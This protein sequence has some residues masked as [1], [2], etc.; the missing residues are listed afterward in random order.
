MT[1][2]ADTQSAD[3]V[4]V[5]IAALN[6]LGIGYMLVGSLSSNVYGVVRSTVDAGV[7]IETDDRVNE[8]IQAIAEHFKVE[9]QIGF[10]TVGMTTKYE[11]H[12]KTTDFKR[13]VFCLTEDEHKQER[14]RR[15]R[16]LEHEGLSIALPTAEDVVI[17]KLRWFRAKG[18]EDVRNVIAVQA[19]R[20]D[21]AYVE[22]WCGRL[23]LSAR[24]REVRDSIPPRLMQDEQPDKNH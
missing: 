20:L 8:F 18:R 14:F 6:R 12:H 23:G 19:G 7:V 3:A 4:R 11:F 1:Q 16:M 2:S 9:P 22:D 5:V 15:R 21:W 10:E 24:L 13:E 17:Q